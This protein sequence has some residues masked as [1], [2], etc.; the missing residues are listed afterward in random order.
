M[1][2]DNCAVGCTRQHSPGHENFYPRVAFVCGLR[3]LERWA[4]YNLAKT[5]IF[6]LIF[7]P[8][9]FL[10]NSSLNQEEE[11]VPAFPE[12]KET[13][14]WKPEHIKNVIHVL[15][16]KNPEMIALFIAAF[17]FFS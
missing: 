6:H 15:I 1:L 8:K 2:K 14:E 3:Q 17:M 5:L 13:N 7:E 10:R 12:E 16:C 4:T 11:G 9:T